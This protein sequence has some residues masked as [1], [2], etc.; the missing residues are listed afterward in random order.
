MR[1]DEVRAKV[2]LALVL[3][4]GTVCIV[5]ALMDVTGLIDANSWIAQRVPALTLLAVGFVASYLIVERRN[6]LDT[7]GDTVEARSKEILEGI[8]SASSRTIEALNGVEVRSF[9]SSAEIVTYASECF[10]KASRIDS[11]TIGGLEVQ[12][13]S[14]KDTTAYLDYQKTISEILY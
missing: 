2:E 6:K 7:I 10:R 1:S 9:A 12:P 8:S 4:I 13:R 14:S 3:I 5:V 11:V